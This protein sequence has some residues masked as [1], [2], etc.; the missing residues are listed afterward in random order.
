MKLCQPRTVRK[1]VIA[2]KE[3]NEKVNLEEAV[4]AVYFAKKYKPVALKVKPVLET[5]LEKFRIIREIIGDPLKDLLKLPEHPLEFSPKGRYMVERK[6]KLDLGH[7]SNFLWPE[8][9]KLMHWI[10]AEQ[11]QAFAWEDNE[12]G[13]FKEE[14]FPVIEILIVVHIPWVERPFRIPPAIHDKVCSIIKRKINTGVYEPSNSSYRSRWF[15]V[16]KKDRKSLCIVHSLKPL[17]RVTIA[18]SGLPLATEE[19]VMHF[20]GRACRGILDLYIEYDKRVLAEH[21]RDL[22][23]FQ[24]PFRALRLVM[25]PIGWTNSVPIFHDDVIYILC[26]EIPRYMLLYIDDMP[27]RG[28][29]TRYEK[30]DSTLEVLEK[31]PGIR[32]FIF[33]HIENINQ[34]LQRMKYTGGTFSG[35]KTKM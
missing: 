17:N 31:N 10:V 14:Y 9:Q 2:V 30:P 7:M 23:M 35:P 24:T 13:K 15:C 1:M 19:L 22:T 18:H 29:T 21:L 16:F 8:E 4:D 6:E 33:K 12:R 11:N 28:P 20:A 27:I 32:Q 34:I 5:L 25:L 26:D 3:D